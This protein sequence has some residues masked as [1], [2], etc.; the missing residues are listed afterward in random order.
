MTERRL[1]RGRLVAFSLVTTALV[2]GGASALVSWLG[3]RG[4]VDLHRPDDRVQ[5]VEEQLFVRD[6]DSFVTTAYAHD[7]M[8]PARVDAER[9]PDG[10]RIF[11]LGGSFALGSPYSH[12][13]DGAETPGGIAS[14]L[15]A[16][17]EGRFPG[18]RVEVV[19]LGAGGEGSH[20]VRRVLE[21]VI[22]LDPDAV[23]VASCN[24]EGAARP[25]AMR[26]Y[27]HT[28]GGYR[29]MT[30]LLAPS[31]DLPG[32][33]LH[34]VQEGTV[35]KLRREFAEN[36][37]AM[38][39]T[40]QE[41]EVPLLLATLP[42]NLR[43]AAYSMSPFADGVDITTAITREEPDACIVA[44]RAAYE[45]GRHAEAIEALAECEDVAEALRWTGLAHAALGHDDDARAALRQSVELL[46]R[47]RCRPSFNAVIEEVAARPGAQLVDLRALAEAEAEQGLPGPP[48][49]LDYCHLH[50][51]GYALM[52]LAIEEQLEAAGVVRGGEPAPDIETIANDFDM[53]SIHQL[54]RVQ[55]SRWN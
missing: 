45:E 10:L 22:D 18:R 44:G 2:L 11:L 9:D 46:P 39:T 26:E 25:S 33:A 41:H 6:G 53:E 8:V 32:R 29:L 12:Q 13:D 7:S 47:N 54:D 19:N 40:A 55:S 28:L 15:R 23:I 14:F 20:R 3:R 4:A 36:L 42:V 51:R 50:W 37:E 17:L 34:T 27:L 24:N 31:G 48:L 35:A 21:E 1:S 52:A 49:F 43:Y 38:R 30:K 5:F 16:R